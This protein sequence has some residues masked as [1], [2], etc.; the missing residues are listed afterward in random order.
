MASRTP[1]ENDYPVRIAQMYY[2]EDKSQAEIAKIVG[3]SRPQI[4]KL[5]MKARELGI[6]TISVA[7]VS[8]RIRN[9][10]IMLC[11]QYLLKYCRVVPDGATVLETEKAVGHNVIEIL[12][13]LHSEVHTVGVGWGAMLNKICEHAPIQ[14]TVDPDSAVVPLIGSLNATNNGYN[15][16]ELVRKYGLMLG[17]APYYLYAPAF[18]QARIDQEQ[19]QE[20]RNFCQISEYWDT[21]DLALFRI[22]VYPCVPDIA[23]SSR[24]GNALIEKKAV[25][26]ILSNFYDIRGQIIPAEDDCS[27]CITRE[28]FLRTPIRLGV[29]ASTTT[30]Q[31]VLGALRTSLVTHLVISESLVREVLRLTGIMT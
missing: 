9:Y 8:D 19:F 5:L 26:T 2:L 22:N 16:N 30:P 13:E 6:V 12:E 25:G 4:S 28:Q 11:Q 10:E 3:V 31:S 27:I 18:P 23:T 1:V 29:C 17:M 24:Y 7:Q 14:D 20:T 15:T 21:M